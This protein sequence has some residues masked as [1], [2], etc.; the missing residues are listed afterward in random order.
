MYTNAIS[1]DSSSGRSTSST[2][3]LERFFLQ[4][5]E[6]LVEVRRDKGPLLEKGTALLRLVDKA[7]YSTFCDCLDL[8]EG[9]EARTILRNEA[10]PP[11]GVDLPGTGPN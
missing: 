7:V 11:H 5:L 2:R 6:R 8:G 3:P 4:R 1:Q 10:V 9:K